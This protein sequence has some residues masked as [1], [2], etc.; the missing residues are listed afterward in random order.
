MKIGFVKQQNFSFSFFFDIWNVQIHDLWEVFVRV[1]II[2]V[3]LMCL[4]ITT[5]IKKFPVIWQLDDF[6]TVRF[7]SKNKHFPQG[8]PVIWE[9]ERHT[10]HLLSLD[11]ECQMHF[12]LTQF[13]LSVSRMMLIKFFV[14]KWNTFYETT[15]WTLPTECPK[16]INIESDINWKLEHN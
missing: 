14:V 10:F 2:A 9:T 13:L 1:C 4:S 16:S 7:I 15:P 3:S 6:G 12:Q 8:N 5:E 11:I